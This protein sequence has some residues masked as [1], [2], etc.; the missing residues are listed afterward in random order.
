MP[1]PF[2]LKPDRLAS[3]VQIQIAPRG[4]GDHGGLPPTIEFWIRAQAPHSYAW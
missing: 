1:E 2:A 3:D 4:D